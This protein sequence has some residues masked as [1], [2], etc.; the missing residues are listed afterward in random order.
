MS[1][2]Q[3]LCLRGAFSLLFL[4]P[5]LEVMGIIDWMDRTLYPGVTENWDDSA[6]REVVLGHIVGCDSD[7]LDLG[8]GA[9]ILP[10]MN[11]KGLARR[12][13]GVD[14]DSRVIQN[15]YLDE[16]FDGV[17][18]ALPFPDDSFDVVVA[19]NVLEHLSD[20][21]RV[22]TEIHRVLRTGGVFLAKTPNRWHYVAGIAAVTPHIFHEWV[23]GRRGRPSPAP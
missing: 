7:V 10:H 12:V 3:K 1:R 4:H 14:P 16:G 21:I 17:G 22:F 18:E 11:F 6:F 15:P 20:P 23:N 8:A 9:G 13:V 2:V 19:D 5:D